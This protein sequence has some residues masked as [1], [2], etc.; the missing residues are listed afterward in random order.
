MRVVC[1]RWDSENIGHVL[2]HGISQDEVDETLQE[3]YR[4]VRSYSGLYMLY[5][6]TS[7]G[8]YVSAAIKMLGNGLARVITALDMTYTERKRYQQ[9]L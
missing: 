7:A 1:F 5:G 4:M 3:P 6:R 2:R 9:L 8:R